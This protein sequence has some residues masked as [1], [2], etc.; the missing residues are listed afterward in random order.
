MG[1]EPISISCPLSS[2]LSWTPDGR[3]SDKMEL[4]SPLLVG[5]L[6][7]LTPDW[8]ILSISCCEGT[9]VNIVKTNELPLPM[10]DNARTP[11][12]NCLHIF[13][14]ILSPLTCVFEPSKLGFGQASVPRASLICWSL[15]PM[16]LSETSIVRNYFSSF[17]ITNLIVIWMLPACWWLTALI[18][19]SMSTRLNLWMSKSRNSCSLWLAISNEMSLSNV[20]LTRSTTF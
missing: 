17:D 19:I 5:L 16:P 20:T 12:S 1:L 13:I 2:Y 11:P 15:M 10:L 14:A 8:L 18:R 4:L 9:W 7:S 6:S 3:L